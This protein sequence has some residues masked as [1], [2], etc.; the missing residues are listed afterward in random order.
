[1]IGHVEHLVFHLKK[2]T[3]GMR[4]EEVDLGFATFGDGSERLYPAPVGMCG[5]RGALLDQAR[6]RTSF[7]SRWM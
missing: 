4:E 6:L 5:A 1:V 3:E 7:R 2:V